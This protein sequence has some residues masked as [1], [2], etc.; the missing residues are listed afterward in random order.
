MNVAKVW[1]SSLRLNDR[2]DILYNPAAAEAKLEAVGWRWW[3]GFG[4]LIFGS[5]IPFWGMVLWRWSKGNTTKNRQRRNRM[6]HER[7]AR[8]KVE[9]ESEAKNGTDD[10]CVFLGCGDIPFPKANTPPWGGEVFFF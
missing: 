3:K 9:R 2:V 7:R 1:P 5:S 10:W 4:A 8:L 6:A